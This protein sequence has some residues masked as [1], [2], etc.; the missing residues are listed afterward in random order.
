MFAGALLLGPAAGTAVAAPVTT[1]LS[2][3]IVSGPE[4]GPGAVPGGIIR[5]VPVTATTGAKSGVVTF[6]PS[7]SPY[8]YQYNYRFITVRWRNIQT[9]AAGSVDVRHWDNAGSPAGDAY[10]AKLPTQVSVQTGPGRVEISA[11]EQRTQYNAPPTTVSLLPGCG[12]VTA[13]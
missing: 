11:V 5:L 6:T 9:G 2:V 8:H 1:P 7:V 4:F 13:S 12:A 3:P 10:P